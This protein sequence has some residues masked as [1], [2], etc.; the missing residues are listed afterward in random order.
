[1]KKSTILFYLP[2]LFFS[3]VLL[4][5][6]VWN[7]YYSFTDWSIL[8][9]IPKVVGLSTYS[10]IFSDTRF[11]TAVIHSFELSGVLVLA[12]NALGILIA[13]LL[14]AVKNSKLRITYMSLFIYP[15]TISMSANGLIFLWLF[16]P[17]YG[18]N[19]LL[20]KLHLPT[21]TWF[22]ATSTELPS[23]IL[24]II[25]AYTGIAMLFYLASFIN[26][27]KSIVEAARMDGAGFFRIFARILVPNSLNGLIVSTA[28]L[29]LFS[30]RVFS[31]PFVISGNASDIYYQTLLTYQ[32]YKFAS[33]YF[34]QSA[35]ASTIV[36]VIALAIVV[37]YAMLG[38][39]RWSHH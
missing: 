16:N 24:I 23:L 3:A 13:G 30:F 31:L 22:A 28:L 11:R 1:M 26:V 17:E 10:Q 37:P 15:L 20:S 8:N 33:S 9:R 4:Y 5:L 34:A 25:W 12:G 29:F 7:V 27:D 19:W 39:K 36:V 6:L 35:A 14:Y 21:Y 38:M 32:Y 2:V 18:I